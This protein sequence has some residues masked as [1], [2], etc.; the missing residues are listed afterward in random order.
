LPYCE[1]AVKLDTTGG[2]LDSRAI[3]LAE[4]GRYEEAVADLEAYLLAWQA[5][6]EAA[7]G[8]NGSLRE[9][10]IRALRSGQ[11]PFD[12]ATLERLRLE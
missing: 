8:R 4:L 2:S 11:D 3:V 7:H 6:D 1:R 9:D 5:Q 10:W 12:R